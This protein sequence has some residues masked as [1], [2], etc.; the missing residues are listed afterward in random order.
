MQAN[1]LQGRR[2]LVTAGPTWVMIDA[3]RHLA[4]FSSGRTGLLFARAAA[5]RGA[6]VTLLMGPGRCLPSEHDRERLEVVDF[7]TFDDLHRLVREHV[8]SR[9]YGALVHAAAVSDYR[10]VSEEQGKLPSGEPELVLHLRPTPKIVDEVK[11]LDPE[12]LLVKFKLEAGK[13]REELLE[14]AAASR[15]RSGA[16]LIVANDLSALTETAHSAYML[17]ENG[18]VAATSTTAELADRLTAELAVRLPA[19]IQ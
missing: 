11:A 17:D 18:L 12:I 9:A 14:I 19:N 15:R 3:V 16:E 6:D 13:S 1:P 8:G 5:E 2:V 7:V 10:P 4:N